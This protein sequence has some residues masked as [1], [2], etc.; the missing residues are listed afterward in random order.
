ML[1][2]CFSFSLLFAFALG[3]STSN[4]GALVRFRIP[5]LPFFNLMLLALYFKRTTYHKA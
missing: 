5:F 2:F 1:I 4:F 3:F